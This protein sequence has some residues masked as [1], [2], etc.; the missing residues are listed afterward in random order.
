MWNGPESGETPPKSG[1]VSCPLCQGG[2]FQCQSWIQ[3]SLSLKQVAFPYCLIA[4]Q[5]KKCPFSSLILA[6]ASQPLKTW[7][8]LPLPD[9]FCHYSPSYSFHSSPFALLPI[10]RLGYN[11]RAFAYA[12]P[13]YATRSPHFAHGSLFQVITQMLSSPC[14]L[15]YLSATITSPADTHTPIHISLLTPNTL[16]CCF[17]LP[18][19]CQLHEGQEPRSVLPKGLAHSVSSVKM[20]TRKGGECLGHIPQGDL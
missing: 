20:L 3:G 14:R 1:L 17:H 15:P 4:H 16:I 9:L 10:N 18:L 12:V 7:S 2:Y 5:G 13:S 19:E 11:P 8:L 6:V